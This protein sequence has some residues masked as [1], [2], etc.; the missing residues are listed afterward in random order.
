[1]LQ[2]Q[3]TE[4]RIYMEC[5]RKF[6]GVAMRYCGNREDALEVFNDS[7][8][9]IIRN[10][11]E[12]KIL[13]ESYHGWCKTVIIHTS[14][15]YLRKRKME[16]V[17]FDFAAENTHGNEGNSGEQSLLQ[18][19]ILREIQKLPNKTRAV[20]NLYVFEGYN[21]KEIAKELD[22]TEGTSH[23]HVNNA[24]KLIKELISNASTILI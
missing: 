24:R 17:D 21:H 1:M 15:D 14:I 22:I 6:F 2:S 12:G 5:Y 8:V 11:K 7:L 19:D 20:F 16:I 10:V 18:E 3:N 13:E 9:K 23:W 4:K